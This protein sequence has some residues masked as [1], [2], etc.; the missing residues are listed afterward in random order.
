MLSVP[1]LL[2]VPDP[3]FTPCQPA[4]V[5]PDPPVDVELPLLPHAAATSARATRPTAAAKPRERFRIDTLP[6]LLMF[7]REVR[8]PGNEPEAEPPHGMAAPQWGQSPGLMAGPAEA[9]P[10]QARGRERQSVP[11]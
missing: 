3:A 7:P 8:P 11:D 5:E 1:P 6:L 2:G 10:L 9:Q 4:T